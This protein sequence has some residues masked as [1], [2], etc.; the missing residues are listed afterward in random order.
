MKPAA[1]SVHPQ[2]ILRI[3]L[4]L[5]AAAT[6]SLAAAE[7]TPEPQYRHGEIVVP[8]F[9]A[10]EAKRTTVSIPLAEEYLRK[11]ALAWVGSQGCVSCHTTGLYM[12]TRPALTRQLGRP[13]E[14]MR[15]FFVQELQKTLVTRREE[16]LTSTR[17]ARV[18]YTAAGLADWD[19]HVTRTLSTETRQALAQMLDLQLDTGTWGTLD[20]WPP[21][22]SDA[23]HLATQAA[24]AIAA[25]PGWLGEL[26][27][28]RHLAGVAKLKNYLRNTPPPHDYGRVLLLWTSARMPDL[29]SAEKKHELLDM[30]SKHQR[31]DGGWSI[32]TFAA[33][34]AWG[35]GNR[36][37][38]LRQEPEF[39]DPPSDGHQTGLALIVLREHG[40][41]ATD[42]RVQHG[43]R[44]LKENQRESGRWWTRSLNTDSSHYITYSGT[45]YPLLAR[46]R[47][48]EI[49]KQPH[50][51]AA[52]PL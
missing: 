10:T 32:R 52:Q 47:W 1:I 8:A 25:A 23:F 6:L 46:G 11:G 33:P 14:E 17:P 39:G 36:A 34:E 3:G 12:V 4:G 48:G 44:W 16:L 22:E 49:P 31:H 30:L 7:V 19:S 24:M 45:A 51:G 21:Y 50:S 13:L 18:I 28:E 5:G 35:G 20:C 9:R 15:T 26:K 29:L 41:L 40:I 37:Q 2:A 43:L 27:D 38:K 42:P